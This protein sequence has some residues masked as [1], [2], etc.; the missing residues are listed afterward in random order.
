MILSPGNRHIDW[1]LL[2]KT[3]RGALERFI[4]SQPIEDIRV[5]GI[6]F[7][8]NIFPHCHSFRSISLKSTYADWDWVRLSLPSYTGIENT[9]TAAIEAP[10]PPLVLRTLSLVTCGE[11]LTK[12]L[13]FGLVDVQTNTARIDMSTL[14]NL[15]ISSL[16]LNEMSVQ[17]IVSSFAFPFV[18]L[19]YNDAWLVFCIAEYVAP[20]F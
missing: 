10:K 14:W 15:D 5:K 2:Y 8:M 13:Q 18:H 17:P 16:E 12:L 7:P 4:A 3:T 1:K 11:V 19:W 6:R 20:N 9:S